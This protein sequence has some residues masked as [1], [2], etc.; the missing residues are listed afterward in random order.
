[1]DSTDSTY[2][3]DADDIMDT[4]ELLEEL[5][6]TIMEVTL[7][8]DERDRLNPSAAKYYDGVLDDMRCNLTEIVQNIAQCCYCHYHNHYHHYDNYRDDWCSLMNGLREKIM[9]WGFGLI[10][11]TSCTFGRGYKV[12]FSPYVHRAD[13]PAFRFGSEWV[14]VNGQ[15]AAGWLTLEGEYKLFIAAE[16]K[17]LGMIFRMCVIGHMI[18]AGLCTQDV[19]GEIL[20]NL[21]DS[22]LPRPEAL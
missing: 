4:I 3:T 16:T 7:S 9:P 6:E 21:Y 10:K 19:A 5:D 2:S 12:G 18:G 1:M 13:Y 17:Y 15:R 14:T 20:Q 22:S 8:Y 11:G